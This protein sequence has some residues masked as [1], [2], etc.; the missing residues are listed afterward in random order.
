MSIY[1]GIPS[2]AYNSEAAMLYGGLAPQDFD[3]NTVYNLLMPWFTRNDIDLDTSNRIAQEVDDYLEAAAQWR[4][5]RNSDGL[6]AYWQQFRKINPPLQD[7]IRKAVNY[8]RHKK[9]I[10]LAVTSSELAQAKS[11]EDALPYLR[12]LPGLGKRFPRSVLPWLRLADDEKELRRARWRRQIGT[13]VPMNLEPPAKMDLIPPTQYQL[14]ALNRR[15]KMASEFAA[16]RAAILRDNPVIER[17]KTQYPPEL[18][19]LKQLAR[20]GALKRE[21]AAL[22]KV[23]PEATLETMRQY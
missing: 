16:A 14:A 23:Y 12:A 17:P 21:L 8:I 18:Q 22:Q 4:L 6:V 9:R 11:W 5:T 10:P 3:F 13:P 1:A 19:R 7:L 20:E 15:R 2:G